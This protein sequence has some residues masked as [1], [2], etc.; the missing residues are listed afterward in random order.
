[1]SGY[2]EDYDRDGYVIVRG[3]MT[4]EQISEM[5][6]ESDAVVQ[7]AKEAKAVVCPHS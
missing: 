7:R 5:Q 1:M 3:A 4:P 6:R 2:R